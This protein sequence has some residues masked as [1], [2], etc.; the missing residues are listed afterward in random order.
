M[1]RGARLPRARDI[2]RSTARADVIARR[3][4]HKRPRREVVTVARRRSTT[5]RVDERDDAARW[6]ACG[7]RTRARCTCGARQGLAPSRRPQMGPGRGISGANSR[8]T[9]ERSTDHRARASAFQPHRAIARHRAEA[10]GDRE[11]KEGPVRRYSGLEMLLETSIAFA[12]NAR[13][14]GRPGRP[15]K[16]AIGPTPG[17]GRMVLVRRRSV[18][19]KNTRTSRSACARRDRARRSTARSQRLLRAVSAIHLSLHAQSRRRRREED[20]PRPVARWRRCPAQKRTV[21]PRR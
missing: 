16:T 13:R 6:K 4:H 15:P 5:S 1:P 10:G 3:D 14:Q 20:S 19:A 2:R 17:M 7:A 12:A 21:Q 8:A 18:V 11:G 9:S